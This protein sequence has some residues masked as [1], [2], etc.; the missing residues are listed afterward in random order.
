[1]REHRR[2]LDGNDVVSPDGSIRLKRLSKVDKFC[3]KTKKDEKGGEKNK[4]EKESR[5]TRLSIFADYT[6]APY[7]A[8]VHKAFCK[9]GG[10]YGGPL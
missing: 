10:Q 3:P 1:M 4:E 7:L 2:L 5:V 6:F 8:R 9:Q